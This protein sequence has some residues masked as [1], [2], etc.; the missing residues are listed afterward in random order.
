M[1][2]TKQSRIDLFLCKRKELHYVLKAFYKN[3][4]ESD[5]DFLWIT[6][7]FTEIIKGQGMWMLNTELLKK[8]IYRI[9]IEGIILNSVNDEMYEEDK[10]FWWDSLKNKIK[11]FSINLSKNVQRAKILTENKVK[12]EWDE[13]MRKITE[14]EKNIDRIIEL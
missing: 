13:E 8:E 14:G 2:E 11:S 6:M 5:H 7:D 3:Y 12:K 1:V 4:S 10:G 9:E